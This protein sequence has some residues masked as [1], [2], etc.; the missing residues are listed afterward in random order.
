[1]TARIKKRA[2][3][4]FTLIELLI[5][6]TIIGVLSG[7]LLLTMGSSTDK[8][9]AT[10][11]VTDLYYADNAGSTLSPDITRLKAYV[12][13]PEKL[14][15]DQYEFKTGENAGQWFVGCKIAS[16]PQGVRDSLKKMAANNGLRNGVTSAD[17]D[18]YD[19]GASGV[20][21]RVR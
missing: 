1:M 6:M 20:Y 14:S 16:Q 15:G 10:R 19:G 11:I 13:A 9:E 12:T 3:R 21:I 17:N 2:R 4:G 7:S 18:V 5:V 8:A